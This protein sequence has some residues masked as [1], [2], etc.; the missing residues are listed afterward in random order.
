M[1][2]ATL[3]FVSKVL[4]GCTNGGR[5]YDC[6]A[7]RKNIMKMEF[8]DV[9]LSYWMGKGEIETWGEPKVGDNVQFFGKSIRKI[10]SRPVKWDKRVQDFRT[11]PNPNPFNNT[12]PGEKVMTMSKDRVRFSL[13]IQYLQAT[14]IDSVLHRAFGVSGK[15]IRKMLFCDRNSVDILCRP[16]QFAR[17][18]IY[19]NDAKITNGFKDLNPKLID[20]K[21]SATVINVMTDA[22]Y[23][24]RS[25]LKQALRD[26]GIDPYGK[27]E[28]K[29]DLSVLDVSMNPNCED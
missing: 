20:P 2:K 8:P 18:L 26:A 4:G 3:N 29:E 19:R 27:V 1:A 21:S 24:D 11:L 17:F 10:V 22:G 15:Q 5:R 12:L 14:C 16:S 25:C 13:G 9:H 28:P 23:F 7:G 6:V